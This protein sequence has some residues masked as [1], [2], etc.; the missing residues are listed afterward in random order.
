MTKAM[1]TKAAKP[2][3]KPVAAKKH[4]PVAKKVALEE[5]EDEEDEDK[6]ELE[7]DA[8]EDDNAPGF[9]DSL[10]G[11]GDNEDDAVAAEADGEADN[12]SADGDDGD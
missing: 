8:E 3:M 2:A 5:D 9:F 6:P 11:G 12:E 10:F 7:E 4:M 1:A